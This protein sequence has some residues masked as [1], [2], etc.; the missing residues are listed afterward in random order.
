MVT[1]HEPTTG[2]MAA[3][4]LFQYAL[5]CGFGMVEAVNFVRQAREDLTPEFIAWLIS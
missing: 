5:D 1:V 3:L 4:G 2:E